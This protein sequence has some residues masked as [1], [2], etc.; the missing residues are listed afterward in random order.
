[1]SQELRLELSGLISQPDDRHEPASIPED[2]PPV[3][4]EEPRS[5]DLDF[6]PSPDLTSSKE[7]SDLE[8]QPG[9]SG[10]DHRLRGTSEG[11]G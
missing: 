10:E 4:R 6:T 3:V 1:M 7:P 2:N 8:P 9:E 5:S 11:S